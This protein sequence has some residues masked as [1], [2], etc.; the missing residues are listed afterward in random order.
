MMLASQWDS[1]TFLVAIADFL[2]RTCLLLFWIGRLGICTILI[3]QYIL[4]VDRQRMLNTF[5]LFSATILCHP[6]EEHH[7][8]LEELN[9]N[10]F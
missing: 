7:S 2:A 10:W 5:L 1:D 4:L 6:A 9:L 3:L 8:P